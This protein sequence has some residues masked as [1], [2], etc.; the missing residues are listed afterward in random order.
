MTSNED[1]ARLY[2]VVQGRS[3]IQYAA[4]ELLAVLS[5]SRN[6]RSF[7]N[8]LSRRYETL[9]AVTFS[10]WR[11]VFLADAT[12]DWD[13]VLADA[14]TFLEKLVRDNSIGYFDD[15]NNRSWSFVYYLN[16]ARFRLKE[17][18]ETWPEFKKGLLD[19]GKALE[20]PIVGSKPLM[21]WE[22]HCAELQIAV[23]L[24]RADVPESWARPWPSRTKRE[25]H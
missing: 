1:L 11:A 17:L 5:E 10:L 14:A 19:S 24:L 22:R 18:A 6:L 3:N 20:E 13:S 23:Q 25:G 8:A 9:V 12:S 4:H 21:M 16:N 7:D 2:T 15:W